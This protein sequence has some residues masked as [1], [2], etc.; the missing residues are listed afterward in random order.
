MN[1]R[2]SHSYSQ[3]NKHAQPSKRGKQI[4]LRRKTALQ[5]AGQL[6]TSPSQRKS[7]GGHVW[8][9]PSSFAGY[10]NAVLVQNA[11]F[12]PYKPK[13]EAP[14]HISKLGGGGASQV[15]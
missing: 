5:H 9:L 13:P 7:H 12:S 10:H 1:G 11:V 3:P 15:Y 8:V 6:G 2:H 4:E 14:L